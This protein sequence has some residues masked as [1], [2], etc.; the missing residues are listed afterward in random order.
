MTK[1][2]LTDDIIWS[3]WSESDRSQLAEEKLAR[4]AADWQLE[5][6]MKWLDK[7]LTNYTDNDYLGDCLPF[8]MLESD[9]KKAM[10]PQEDNS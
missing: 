6:V 4:A 8:Y 5:Q 2:P 7:N 9:L 3:M 10:R 1:H